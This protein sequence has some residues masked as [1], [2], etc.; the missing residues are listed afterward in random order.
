MLLEGRL[1]DGETVRVDAG[2]DGLVIQGTAA[3]AAAA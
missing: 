1:T 3:T 2:E